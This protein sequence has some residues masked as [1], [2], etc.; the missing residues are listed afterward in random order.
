MLLQFCQKIACLSHWTGNGKILLTTL[1]HR[2]ICLA[3]NFFARK[4]N[5]IYFFIYYCQKVLLFIEKCLIFM[6]EKAKLENRGSKC[7]QYNYQG[8][9]VFLTQI[10]SFLT[11]IFAG[12]NEI[13]VTVRGPQ[14]A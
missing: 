9:I 12:E 13:P 2:I 6:L 10:C 11:Q 1:L 8:I 5:F 3:L 14:G 7:L 4:E